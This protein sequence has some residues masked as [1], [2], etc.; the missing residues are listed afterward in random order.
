MISTNAK[1]LSQKISSGSAN[2]GIIGMGY[3]GLPLSLLFA[4]AGFFLTGFDIDQEKVQMLNAG[5]SYIRH[6]NSS[7]ILTAIKKGKFIATDDFSRLMEMDVIII[8]VPTPLAPNREPDLQFVIS[9][10]ETIAKHLKSE[11]LIILESTTYPGTTKEIVK[12]ILEAGGLVSGRDFFLAYSPER[13][14]PGN[15]DFKTSS[16][17]KVLG[18]DGADACDLTNELYRE[19]I[20]QTVPVSNMDTAEASKLTENIFRAVNIALVNELKLIYTELGIDIWEVI[21]AASTKPF[22]F[23]PFFPGPGLGGHCI[24]IDPFY[25]SW[26]ARQVGLR[27]RFIELSGEINRDMPLYV[28]NNLSAALMERF[29]QTLRGASVLIVGIAYKKNCDDLRESPA[30]AII[31]LLESRGAVT[32]Y[33]DPYIPKI[34]RTREYD[35]LAGRVSI[36][37]EAEKLKTFHGVL[38]CAD[39]DS[40]DY[41]QL[42]NNAQLVVD[43]RNATATVTNR[44]R[45]VLS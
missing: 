20:S 25:L 35:V 41:E 4:E 33:H 37:L 2:V 36:P 12:P 21:E 11:K 45:V 32:E 24:P 40:V 23:M 7:D 30:L 17:P 5:K 6:V 22:G 10:S 38:I 39:H 26:R 3:V 43:T 34:G 29:N 19:V 18:G 9:T 13:E 15:L 14:D 31:E 16:I 42:V 28:V 27:T 44:E 1:E 8:C